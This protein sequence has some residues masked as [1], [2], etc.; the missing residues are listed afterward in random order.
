MRRLSIFLTIVFLIIVMIYD[1]KV[2]TIPHQ[3]K[4]KIS[5]S[6]QDSKKPTLAYKEIQTKSGDTVLSV[7]ESMNDNWKKVSIKQIIKDFT[8]LNPD[9]EPTKIQIGKVY[10]FPLYE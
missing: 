10:R 3:K 9:T 4:E 5:T 8:I 1:M 6:K 7:V 2:G